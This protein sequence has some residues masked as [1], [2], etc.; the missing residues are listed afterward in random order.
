VDTQ[1]E[2]WNLPQLQLGSN[3]NVAITKKWFAGANVFFIGERMD[4]QLDQSFTEITS[5]KQTLAGYFDANLN[6][7]YRHNERIT[8]FLK[9]NN[10]ANQAYEKWL[11]YPVQQLQLLLG[12]SYKFDF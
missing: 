1:E 6:L 10:I 8:A 11:N 4:F 5:G 7:G 3:L 12:A 2:A 9:A